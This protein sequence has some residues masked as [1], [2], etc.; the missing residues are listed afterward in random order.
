MHVLEGRRK[1]PA[2]ATA[3]LLALPSEEE[4]GFPEFWLILFSILFLYK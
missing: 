1:P 3:L 2:V 4:E